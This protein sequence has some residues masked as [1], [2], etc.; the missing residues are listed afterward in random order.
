MELQEVWR[1]CENLNYRH[2]RNEPKGTGTSRVYID[3]QSSRVLGS[4]N[5][6]PF[7]RHVTQSHDKQ[8]LISSLALLSM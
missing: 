7:L 3:T 8:F 6:V 4:V 5:D 1:Q 2:K